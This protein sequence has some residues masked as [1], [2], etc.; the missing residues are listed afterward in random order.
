MSVFYEDRISMA[1]PEGVNLE[2]TLA[3]VGSRFVAAVIDQLIRWLVML[4]LFVGLALLGSRASVP[5]PSAADS[6][7]S[8]GAV[9]AVIIVIV[10]LI[11][12]G[13]DVM[14]ETLAS[15]RTPGKRW[16][17]LRVVRVGGAP[18]GF[19][20]SALRNVMRLVDALPG[21]YAV[22]IVAVLAS[23]NNQRLGDMAAGTLVVRE[24]LA[25]PAPA[26][27]QRSS[28][29]AAGTAL[30]DVSSISPDE[31]A[32]VRRFLDRRPTLTPEARDRL[33]RQLAARLR[34]KVVGPPPD[35]SAE[36]FLEELAAA[37]AGRE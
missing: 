2:V 11:Q 24:R 17:G 34:P 7:M 32:T 9:V 5:R 25:R 14:F 1:T 4:A 26:T 22:G 13:Y 31:M 30:W 3:G 36:S 10:F 16:T 18:V 27:L 37:K 15:G 33:G 19:V 21:V 28:G 20:A 8:G 12:F 35:L 23:R 29:A 6:A